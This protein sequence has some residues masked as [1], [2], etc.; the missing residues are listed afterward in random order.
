MITFLK[1]LF[2]VLLLLM[3]Y[4]VISTSLQSNL[5]TEWNFLGSIPWMRATLCDFYTNVLF[6]FIWVVYKERSVWKSIMWLILLC[7]LGSIA[8]CIY[9]LI[10]LF[11]LREGESLKEFFS[12]Q[13]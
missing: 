5:F 9:I 4:E 7:C 8:T 2:S 1:I 12:K 6:I 3:C 13:N 10:Q 11:R